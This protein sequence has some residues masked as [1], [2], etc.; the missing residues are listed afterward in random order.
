M[1]CGMKTFF[2]AILLETNRKSWFKFGVQKKR[3]KYGIMVTTRVWNTIF[4]TKK[5]NG[6][7]NF[8]MTP[9]ISPNI[10]LL[11]LSNY[12]I[13]TYITPQIFDNWRLQHY[14]EQ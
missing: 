8:E 7:L 6:F 14:N 11:V 9:T 4:K 2:I 12:I 1:Q 3:I 13:N 5:F 10:T